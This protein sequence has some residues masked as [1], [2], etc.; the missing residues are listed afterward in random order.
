MQT[1]YWQ[2]HITT[3]KGMEEIG[4]TGIDV[5]AEVSRVPWLTLQLMVQ[6]SRSLA[7]VALIRL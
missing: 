5:S 7:D 4:Q 3:L 2:L 6:L 1:L